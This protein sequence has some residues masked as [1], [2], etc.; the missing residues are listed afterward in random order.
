MFFDFCLRAWSFLGQTPAGDVASPAVSTTVTN[1]AA[2]SGGGFD[3]LPYVRYILMVVYFLV[4]GGLILI[5]LQKHTKSDGLTGL[6]GAGSANQNSYHGK[7]SAEENMSLASNYLAVSFI[8]LS[9]VIS[10][11]MH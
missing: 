7:R 3:W 10:L 1:S 11:V 2:A 9:M 8:V 5:V 4:C 6:A